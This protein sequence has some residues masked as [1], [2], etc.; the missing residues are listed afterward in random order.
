MYPSLSVLSEHW[1]NT[2]DMKL[3]TNIYLHRNIHTYSFPKGNWKVATFNELPECIWTLTN[4]LW[5]ISSV[6]FQSLLF[7]H[8]GASFLRAQC[9]L[10]SHA[11]VGN[12]VLSQQRGFLP[13]SYRLTHLAGRVLGP[14]GQ[15]QESTD[16]E[17]SAEG[18]LHSVNP[19]AGTLA[20][21]ITGN[22][23]CTALEMCQGLEEERQ[24]LPLLLTVPVFTC[25]AFAGACVRTNILFFWI[26]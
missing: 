3:Y 14:W 23:F 10:K 9:P 12:E 22:T 1:K 8:H 20:A 17:E 21:V 19:E 18:Q 2:Y 11:A 25:F 7:P 4:K 6:A 13:H 5:E 26:R 24:H 16:E 15:G